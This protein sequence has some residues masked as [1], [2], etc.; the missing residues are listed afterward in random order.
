MPWAYVIYALI[1]LAIIAMQP[2]PKASDAKP[3]AFSDI[4][5]PTADRTRCIPVLFGEQEIRGPNNTWAGDFGTSEITEEIDGGW[6]H[7][8]QEVVVAIRYHV[9]MMF[10]LCYGVVDQLTKIRLEEKVA[11]SGLKT[12]NSEFLVDKQNLY[13]GEESQGGVYAY[14]QFYNGSQTQGVNG[15][16][17]ARVGLCPSY[18]GVS[19][20]LWK[21]KS[22]GL[23]GGYIG[24]SP[25]LKPF[26]FTV[27]RWPNTL[28]VGGGKHKVPR[29]SG[30]AGYDANP[31]CVAYEILTNEEWGMGFPAG[32]IDT[33]NFIEAAETLYAE[34]FGVSFLWTEEDAI[35]SVLE[36]LLRHLSAATTFDFN[37]GKMKLKLIRADYDP[38]ALASF[39][40]DDVLDVRNYTR[41]AWRDTLNEVVVQFTDHRT[42]YTENTVSATDS[43]NAFVQNRYYS[44]SVNMHMV[45]D[46]DLATNLAWTALRGLSGT[47]ARFDVLLNRRGYDMNIGDVF[48]VSKP[49]LGIAQMIVRIIEADY[50]TATDGKITFSV[51]EDVFAQ[52]K[53]VYS[54]PPP[55]SSGFDITDPFEA[56]HFVAVSAPQ[57]LNSRTG[58]TEQDVLFFVARASA[59]G[60]VADSMGYQRATSEVSGGTLTFS[61]LNKYTPVG[62]LQSD[63]WEPF[64]GETI[65]VKGYDLGIIENATDTEIRGGK[66]ICYI[67]DDSR[68]E[69]VAFTTVAYDSLTDVYTLS[70]L[71]RGMIDTI[72]RPHPNNVAMTTG[73]TKVWF[74]SYGSSSFKSGLV[75]VSF[76]YKIFPVTL[77]GRLDDA[78]VAQVLYTPLDRASR[79]Y[80]PRHMQFGAVTDQSLQ[81]GGADSKSISSSGNPYKLP[82]KVS[83]TSG[84]YSLV[85]AEN[86]FYNIRNAQ[87]WQLGSTNGHNRLDLYTALLA[88]TNFPLPAGSSSGLGATMSDSTVVTYFNTATIYAD[89]MGARPPTLLQLSSYTQSTVTSKYSREAATLV[90]KNA[91]PWEEYKEYNQHVLPKG[92][93]VSVNGK[94][95]AM[96][97]KDDA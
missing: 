89:G 33:A 29:L 15:Y 59:S 28:G 39:G 81:Y 45:T 8:D 60:Y 30:A 23:L 55:T 58:A 2:R 91:Y 97:V 93:L 44:H 10:S 34:R 69:W 1:S 67:E 63:M 64:T 16:M 90:A 37:T 76:W 50:G 51:V 52:S 49:S 40:E 77:K 54:V 11:F 21:G 14:C 7:S 65:S 73:G 96:W 18:K 56:A 87:Y 36:S 19:Y 79:P 47:A 86:F 17:N 88:N 66:N 41:G 48:K 43:A 12:D 78:T 31:A 84:D 70:G 75:G 25:S 85:E 5:F 4:D 3:A 62:F 32:K 72:P 27:A 57:I 6:F 61:A 22:R 71:R 26:K 46:V 95:I 13:G 9:G 20:L 92:R 42:K 68:S 38:D 83:V 74:A 53:S 94:L 82:N 35:R 24:M 80:M